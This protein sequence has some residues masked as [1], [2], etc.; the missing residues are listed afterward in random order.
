MAWVAEQLAALPPHEGIPPELRP[1]SLCLAQFSLDQRWYRAHVE[2]ALAMP[3]GEPGYEVG[4]TAWP[5]AARVC[6]VAGGMTGF[7]Q[8]TFCALFSGGVPPQK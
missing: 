1:G 7:R 5:R 6:C 8:L 3:S 4:G 2:R